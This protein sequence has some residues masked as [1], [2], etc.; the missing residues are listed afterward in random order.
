MLGGSS[1]VMYVLHIIALETSIQ[2]VIKCWRFKES[3]NAWK[4]VTGAIDG[5]Q[6]RW[7]P[8]KLPQELGGFQGVLSS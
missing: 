2:D 8:R 1:G 7:F 4:L 5:F 3:V 6:G